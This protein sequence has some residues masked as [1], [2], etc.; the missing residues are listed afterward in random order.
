MKA[1]VCFLVQSLSG[2]A[3]A[4]SQSQTISPPLKLFSVIKASKRLALKGLKLKPQQ[5]QQEG[6]VDGLG[7]VT[8]HSTFE[9]LFL[10]L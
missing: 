7:V 4:A 8:P 10:Q 6:E 3:A 5:R 9:L 2:E 1:G